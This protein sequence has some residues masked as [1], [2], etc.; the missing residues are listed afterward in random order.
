MC[1][2]AIFSWL[3]APQVYLPVSLCRQ[4]KQASA[5]TT[6]KMRSLASMALSSAPGATMSECDS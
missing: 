3:N 2:S 6:V 4:E 1:T 5:Q